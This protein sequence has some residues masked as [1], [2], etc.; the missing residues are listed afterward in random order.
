MG[1]AA[2]LLSRFALAFAL[3][4]AWSLGF[5]ATV[6]AVHH[7]IDCRRRP[8]PRRGLVLFAAMTAIVA[9]SVT[10]AQLIPALAIGVPLI[11]ASSVLVLRPPHPRHLR[12]VG[13]V[14]VAASAV[15]IVI[16]TTVVY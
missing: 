4:A 14:L 2:T 15:S 5:A 3:C 8:E 9:G 1:Y 12:A 16:A 13:V 7:V 11:L 10:G 6:I